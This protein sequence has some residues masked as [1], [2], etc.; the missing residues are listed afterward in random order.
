ML[1]IQMKQFLSRNKWKFIGSST[2]G[3]GY[4]V[5]ASGATVA[6]THFLRRTLFLGRLGG[7]AI[8]MGM[9]EREVRSI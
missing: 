2:L 1:Y 4:R 9:E 5:E 3:P 8:E 6:L 7:V